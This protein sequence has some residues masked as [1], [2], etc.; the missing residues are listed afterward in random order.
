MDPERKARKKAAR[1]RRRWEKQRAREQQ[2]ARDEAQQQPLSPEEW[3]EAVID[4]LGLPESRSD[5]EQWWFGFTIVNLR[6]EE[7]DPQSAA[8]RIVA[9]MNELGLS[10]SHVARMKNGVLGVGPVESRMK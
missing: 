8:Q 10:F 3:V 6:E 1:Q 5:Q 2:A 4:A 7:P 9:M